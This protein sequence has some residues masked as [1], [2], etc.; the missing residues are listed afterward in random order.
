MVVASFVPR[1]AVHPTIG[2]YVPSRINNCAYLA[3]VCRAYSLQTSHQ[4]GSAA[5]MKEAVSAITIY[6][7]IAVSGIKVRVPFVL[8]SDEKK[9]GFAAWVT[10]T[11]Y[12]FM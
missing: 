3:S 9:L 5:A 10:A 4:I 7:A 1:R 6:L 11:I 2:F 8:I 12:D